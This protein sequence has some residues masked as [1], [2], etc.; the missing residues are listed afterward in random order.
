[1]SDFFTMQAGET[2]APVPDGPVL[3]QA[4]AGMRRIHRVFLWSYDEAPGLVRSA[5][6]GDTE[7]SGYVGEVLGNFDK[8]LHVHHE[9]EDLY[10]YP[11]LGERAPACA[12]HIAQMLAQHE[13]VEQALDDLAP[14]RERW[15]ESADA[16]LGEQLAA[17]YEDLSA[18]LKVHL[19]REVTEVTAAVEKVLTE[20]EFEQLSSHGVDAFEK[21]VVL[22]YLGMILATNPPDEQRAFIMDIPLPIRMAYRLVGKRLYRKQY[23]TLFP[24]RA[25]PQTI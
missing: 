2:A 9:G 10:M 8:L 3:C 1:M 18:M 25:I 14:I 23:A 24:G 7:R 11:Q 17:R 20:E 16:E 12:L 5:A 13:Q 4:T 22:A 21:K 6:D 19:R 15:R